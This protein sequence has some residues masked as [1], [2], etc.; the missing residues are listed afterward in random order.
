[1]KLKLAMAG[2]LAA[3]SFHSIAQAQEAQEAE[4]A[5]APGEIIVT[6]QKREQSIQD[7]S[8][9][10]TAVGADQLATGQIDNIEDLQ[11]L[12]PSISIGNDFNQAKLF[13]RGVGAN[14]S[15][16]GSST[17]VALHV[18]GVYVARAEAQLT[19]LFDLER[20]EVVRGPQGSLYGR[21]AVGGSLN[22]ITAKPS[23]TLEGYARGTYGNYNAYTIDAAIGGAITDSVLVRLAGKTEDRDGFGENPFTGTEVDNLERRMMRAQVQ[24]LLSEKVDFLLSGEYFTQDDN[25]GAIKF[26]APAFPGIARLAPLGGTGIA[27]RPRDL[28]G[29]EPPSVKTDTYSITGTINIEAT[30]TLSI[31]NITNYRD[32]QTQIIQDLDAS[33]IVNS[34]TNTGQATTVQR[35]DVNSVQYSNELQ[36]K[37]D[38]DILKGV[39]GLFYFHE[40]QTPRDKVG[41]STATGMASNITAL[42]TRPVGLN[43]A[44]PSPA[45]IGSIPL[46]EALALCGL[47][48]APGIAPQRVCLTS[49]LRTDAFAAFGQANIDLGNAIGLNGVTL[50]I[51]GRYSLEDVSTRNP[52]IIIAGN[53]AGPIFRTTSAATFRS[54]SF[55]DFT[56]ELGI[57]WAPNS[58][59]L[60]YYTYSE[61]FKAGSGENAAGSTIIVRP[62]NVK[63]HELG[64][65]AELFDRKLSINLAAYSYKLDD[66]QIN[67]TVGGGP[68]G[69]TTIFENA[70]KTSAKGVELEFF[71]RP[72]DFF[73]LSGGVSYIDSQFDDFL[74]LDPLNPVNVNQPAGTLRYNPLLPSGALLNPALPR[75]DNVTAFGGPCGTSLTTNLAP[76][77]IQLAGNPTRNT[78]RWSYSLHAE[79]DLP[80]LPEDSGTITLAGDMAGRSKIFFTEFARLTEG[81]RSFTM[82]DAWLRWQSAD[83][84]IS[85]QGWVKNIANTFRPTSTFAV[86]TGRLIGATYLPPRTYGISVGYTF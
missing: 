23:A 43:G 53:G 5:L 60:I 35:R 25:S 67:K 74:T 21:N 65:K 46:A 77:N 73:R 20:V 30:D 19:S 58:D 11:M 17:G 22:L 6:A 27:T 28:A 1:M 57:Q 12:V 72:T 36:F 14:T 47:Q 29:D 62:E 7:V 52:S 4:D 8:A 76:C 42:A 56:P 66:L 18:D 69:F 84:A 78:P 9:A 48:N 68:A 10:V 50:K 55:A 70:A 61:A 39:L 80:I 33:Q 51:G 37:Y 16:T 49:D 34:L 64:I 38:S 86:S 85:V 24:F 45:L 3:T 79:L 54:R 2:L 15:T 59:L 26:F 75:N 13:I 31:T 41:L 82:F 32:F 81:S 83:R 40:R 63:N 71:A 44:P